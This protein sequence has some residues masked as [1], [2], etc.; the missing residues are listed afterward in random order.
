MQFL[1]TIIV[2]TCD[3]ASI[4]IRLWTEVLSSVKKFATSP[5][6]GTSAFHLQQHRWKFFNQAP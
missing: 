6:F 2:G 5:Y 4:W 1:D 3:N